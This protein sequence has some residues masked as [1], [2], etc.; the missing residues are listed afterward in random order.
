M[1]TNDVHVPRGQSVDAARKN[2]A[3]AFRNH[4]QAHLKRRPLIGVRQ[5]FIRR[6]LCLY[7]RANGFSNLLHT[8]SIFVKHQLFCWFHLKSRA[9]VK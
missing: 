4:A 8:R 1:T 3:A 2:Y 7:L 9:D 5:E 6:A